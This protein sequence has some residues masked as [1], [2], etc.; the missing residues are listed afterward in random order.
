MK[1]I[2][3][4]KILFL[5]ILILFVSSCKKIIE[6]KIDGRWRRVNVNNVTSDTF[7][8]WQLNNG[9]LYV[10]S[11]YV[12]GLYTNTISYGEYV[13]KSKFFKRFFSVTKTSNNSVVSFGDWKI[14]KL[15]KQHLIIYRPESG[16]Y[17][18]FEKQ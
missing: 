4:L 6:D 7:E 14:E 13:I 18:E 9:S 5:I 17:I 16:L 12:N 3:L 15:T 1:S 8:E 11:I 10:D 2:S